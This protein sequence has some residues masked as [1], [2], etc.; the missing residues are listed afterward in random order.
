M[1]CGPGSTGTSPP[2]SP[3]STRSPSI[4]IAAA[5]TS[6]PSGTRIVSFGRLGSIFAISSLIFG[7][8]LSPLA[9]AIFWASTYH[10]CA[11]TSLP[12]SS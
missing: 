8:R 12:H 5:S 10:L 2:M 4:V 1:T 3:A 11:R 6:A 7:A 9:A